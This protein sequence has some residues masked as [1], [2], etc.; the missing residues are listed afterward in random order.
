MLDH[1]DDA[2]AA[3]DDDDESVNSLFVLCFVRL[4]ALL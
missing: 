4:V 3:D 2:A 1:D